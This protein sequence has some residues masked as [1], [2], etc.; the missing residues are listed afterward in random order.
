MMKYS[1]YNNYVK[2]KDGV[3]AFNAMTMKFLYLV[4]E[5]MELINN[6]PPEQIAT[7][8]PDFYS[9]L[10]ANRFICDDKTDEY[11]DAVNLMRTINNDSKSY[12]LIVNPTT[13]CNFHCWYCYE[14]HG[15]SNKM[16]EETINRVFRYIENVIKKTELEHFQ[17]SFF[18]GEP[19]LHFKNVILPIAKYTQE[20]AIRYGKRYAMDITSNAYLFN[21]NRFKRL[22]ELGLKSCQITLDGNEDQHN[23][24]RFPHRGVGSYSIITKNIHTAVKLGIKVVLRINY[25]KENLPNLYMIL[26]DFEDLSTREKE[27]I[28]L[29]MNKVWQET[30]KDLTNE[31]N[32]FIDSSRKFGF[33]IPDAFLADHVRNSCYADKV[34]EAVINYDG[35]IY[36][37]NARDFVEE[38][39]EGILDDEGNIIWNKLHSKS[40]KVRNTNKQC[41]M[42]SVFPICGGGCSQIALENAGKDYCIGKAA[43]EDTIRQMFLSKY[44]IK[45]DV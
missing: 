25:T 27:L 18:G 15:K 39:H 10:K 3:I 2:Y 29:S 7:V 28:T 8:H 26:K 20:C 32:Q 41:K 24:T 34:N 45:K 5:L 44:C 36:K 4:P 42:C 11:I 16:D 35:K 37:C 19:L 30:N 9:A 43:V 13:N 17:L 14:N 1:L 6:Y 31:V 38:R 12:R 22:K 23:K 21:S 40:L 33:T